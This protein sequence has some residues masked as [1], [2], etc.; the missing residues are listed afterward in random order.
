MKNPLQKNQVGVSKSSKSFQLTNAL[1][2]YAV[3]KARVGEVLIAGRSRIEKEFMLMRYHT[4]LLI[5]E[6]VRLNGG[7]AAYGTQA[8]AK[9][10]KDFDI[11][12]TELQRYSQFARAYPILGGR[13]ELQFNL[14]WT[15]Y[16][17]LMVIPNDELRDR[18]TAQAEKQGW[19]FDEVQ[20][21]VRYA[22]GKT[23]EKKEIAPLAPVTLGEFHTYQII[24]PESVHGEKPELVIDC[25]FSLK[26]EL[27]ELNV[28]GKFKEG[29]I[30]TSVWKGNRYELS[31]FSP[32]ASAADQPKRKAE[33]FLYTY[34]AFVVD[35]IDGDTLKVDFCLGFGLRKGETIRLN[36][37][38][39]PEMNT[40][41][42]KAAKRFVEAQLAGCE[43]I[44]VKS[45]KTRKEKWGRYLG[46]V[47][48]PQ[49]AGEP[50]YFN[51]LL[52]DK[53]CAVQVH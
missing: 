35:V 25:G 43:F 17:K 11:D 32:P 13:R 49:K 28:R 40:P 52:L 50:V 42:G 3:L 24:R 10:E 48:L 4:G 5:N 14:P 2:D 16:R 27:S 31:A 1:R 39:C 26:K 47:F 51:Q 30:V 20:T 44:I 19:S 9:L 12:H 45:V 8:F 29:A 34:K 37:I 53:G 41:E 36:H 46:E 18:L 38:D 21:K 23:Q 6:H 33:S 15:H 22:V 7:R